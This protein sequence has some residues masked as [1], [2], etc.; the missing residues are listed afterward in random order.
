MI[1]TASNKSQCHT[2]VTCPVVIY[3]YFTYF[4]IIDANI[5]D[6]QIWLYGYIFYVLCIRITRNINCIMWTIW[7]EYL[8][9]HHRTCSKDDRIISCHSV[10]F[11]Q[12]VPFLWLSAAV[13]TKYQLADIRCS[14]VG[15][16][17]KC[18]IHQLIL[19]G[20]GC[21]A[22]RTVRTGSGKSRLR[23]KRKHHAQ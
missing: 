13:L 16:R 23:R 3:I 6:I 10:V 2:K 1:C 8:S 4:S 15:I 14:Y 11:I 18:T 5:S 22:W 7:T 9:C 19:C 20:I 17:C 21:H 12:D